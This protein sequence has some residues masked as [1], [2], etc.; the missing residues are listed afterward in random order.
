MPALEAAST[1]AAT[2]IPKSVA[3]AKA[4]ALQYPNTK[5]LLVSFHTDSGTDQHFGAFYNSSYAESKKIGDAILA[6][7]AVVH[8]K[9]AKFNLDQTG[10][11]YYALPEGLPSNL[12]PILI[13]AAAH[14]GAAN[15]KWIEAHV[16]AIAQAFVD[17]TEAYVTSGPTP[18]PP[19]V[20]PCEQELA[21]LKIT[22]ASVNAE[23]TA[24]KASLTIA[25]TKLANI[26]A[27]GGW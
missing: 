15:V 12:T 20:T 16:D 18:T 4:Y 1:D 11:G 14:E 23:L 5:F 13:E 10:A 8:G 26:K 17:G 6:K 3:L 9:A 2:A 19:P 24:T 27:A 7:F 21:A 25:N 22:L